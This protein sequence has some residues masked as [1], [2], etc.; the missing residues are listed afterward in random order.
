MNF[1]FIDEEE[2]WLVYRC[3]YYRESKDGK[4]DRCSIYPFRHR[5]CR[6]FPRR[7]LYGHP[8]LHEDCGFKFVRRDVLLRRKKFQ[9]DGERLF[10]DVLEEKR[11]IKN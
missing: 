4:G 5:L 7:M 2:G 8:S 1:Y 9:S 6:F 3:R 11:K 10:G